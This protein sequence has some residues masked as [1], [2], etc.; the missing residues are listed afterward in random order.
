MRDSLS[1]L[2][3]NACD[4]ALHGAADGDGAGNDGENEGDDGADHPEPLYS[5]KACL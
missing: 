3:D 1:S 4:I 2:E 5:H